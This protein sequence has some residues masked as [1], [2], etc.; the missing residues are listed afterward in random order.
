[1]PTQRKAKPATRAKERN[2]ACKLRKPQ[3]RKNPRWWRATSAP[4]CLPDMERQARHRE[5]AVLD[6]AKQFEGDVRRARP[7]TVDD[8]VQ[9]RLHFIPGDLGDRTVT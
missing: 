1:M 3:A 7:A 6:A 4:G 8:R 5:H 9:Q 2:G